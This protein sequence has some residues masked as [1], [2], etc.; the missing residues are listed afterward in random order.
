MRNA[1]G[2]VE[3]VLGDDG[4]L[5]DSGGSG[6]TAGAS[7]IYLQRDSLLWYDL[8]EREFRLRDSLFQGMEK[9]KKNA[10]CLS[11]GNRRNDAVAASVA[12]VFD[13]AL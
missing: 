13:D 4:G 8:K 10:G 12:D 1:K 7:L 6:G 5:P 11:A 3:L 2:K 9:R